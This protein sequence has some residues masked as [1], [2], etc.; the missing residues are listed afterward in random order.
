MPEEAWAGGGRAAMLLVV[1]TCLPLV[2]LKLSS[3]WHLG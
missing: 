3:P 2:H 1:S